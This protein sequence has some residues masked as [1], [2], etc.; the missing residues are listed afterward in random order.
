MNATTIEDAP[1]G[2][3]AATSG[4]TNRGALESLT[5]RR[6]TTGA[7]AAAR[8]ALMRRLRIA[9]PTIALILLAAFFV[10][11]R[12]G[13]G[14]EAFLEDFA[15]V[16]ATTQNLSSEK[17]QFSGV[18]SRGNPYEITAES[19][20]Q[21][22][23]NKDLV[24]LDRPRAVTAGGKDNSVVEAATGVFDTDAKTLLLRDGVTLEHEIGRDNYVLRSATATVSI[25]DQTVKTGNGV[26]GEGPRGSTL[27]A[28]RMQ[29]NNRDG[30]VIFEGDVTMRMYPKEKSGDAPT[31]PEDGEKDE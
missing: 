16:N 30:I 19:A 20:S 4:R 26:V 28:D 7:E 2:E 17:P 1:A 31:Q 5:I 23:D 18:D 21:T 6:R 22:P 11:T 10:T 12:K 9:L 15:D 8:A 14:D 3:A 29:A 27:K 25:D 24:E 13:G